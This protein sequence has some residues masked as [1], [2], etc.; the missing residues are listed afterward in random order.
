MEKLLVTLKRPKARVLWMLHK[1]VIEPM[2][3]AALIDGVPYSY[4]VEQA[5]L[6][7]LRARVAPRKLSSL[8]KRRSITVVTP[9]RRKTD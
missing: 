3:E 8:F 6:E 5:I 9:R 4:W 2:H 7:K 1:D